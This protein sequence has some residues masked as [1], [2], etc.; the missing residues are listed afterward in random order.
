MLR[1]FQ[2]LLLICAGTV[3]FLPFS[4]ETSAMIIFCICGA[5]FALT[6]TKKRF[7][8][9]SAFVLA[10]AYMIPPEAILMSDAL[11]ITWGEEHVLAGWRIL[12]LAFVAVNCGFI[13]FMKQIKP[14]ERPQIH[15]ASPALMNNGK[16]I[17]L[18][19][20]I[21]CVVLFSPMIVYGL[22]TGRG[23]NT[24]HNPE[25]GGGLLFPVG[26]LG[27]FLFSLL[28]T[29]CGF[30]GYCFSRENKGVS[31]FLKTLLF[32]SPIL[33]IGI[34][35][36]TRYILC[37]MLSSV[38][39]PWI[40]KL[41]IKNVKWLA[42][43]GIA[44]I[45]LFSAMK[46]SRYSGFELSSAFETENLSGSL[47]L[48]EKIAS[49]G[50]P[51]GLLRNMAMIDLWTETH[52]HTY[53]KSI[54]FLGIFWIPRA[55][56]TE[57]PTQLNYWLIREYESGFGGG[58]STSSSFCGELFMDFGY[59]C[60]LAAFLLGVFMSKMDRYVEKNLIAGGFFATAISGIL[61][62]WAFFMTRSILTASYPLI[63]GAPMLW[64]LGKFLLKETTLPRKKNL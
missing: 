31:S 29:I 3:I 16:R 19:L 14:W 41:K 2:Y 17:F 58:Y 63:L 35:S 48:S 23:S 8:L 59:G 52:P 62:S 32:S 13:M 33:L 61:F 22:T 25:E 9:L 37:F 27:Y 56:W 24:L 50:S 10:F 5:L 64:F 38:F 34:A 36:G 11:S 40:Y 15:L 20:T 12:V 1:F 46:N 51:E 49:K 30:W 57:K 45:L 4:I 21:F 54:G 53:G 39:L 47:S 44:L 42:V 60:I 7:S 55:I 6:L 26:V 43:G 28:Y 18:F